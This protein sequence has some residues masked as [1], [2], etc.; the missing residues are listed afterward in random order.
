MNAENA[1]SPVPG[2]IRQIGFVVS[3]LDE[4]ISG[5]IALGVGPWHVLR[6]QHQRASYRGQ[7]CEVTLNIALANSGDLQVELITQ[8][9]DADS[10][11]TE[12]LASSGGGFHQ[13]GYW[14]EDFDATTAHITDAGWPLVWSG[15]ETDGVRYAY[16]EPPGSPAAII[17][18]MELNA[19]TAG[20]AQ[21]VE[22]AATAWDGADPIR[23]LLDGS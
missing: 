3:D 16:F 14:T 17:E 22:A 6:G 9:N 8:A 7:P 21:L 19:A 18:V 23:V 4:A 11:Y 13:L 12:F 20:L 2:P 10:I 1:P 15:G 5:W